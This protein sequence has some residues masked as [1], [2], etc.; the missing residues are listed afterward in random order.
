MKKHVIFVVSYFLILALV[1]GMTFFLPAR[2]FS[3][4]ENRVL[5]QAPELNVD[6]LL[7]GDFQEDLSLFLSDQIPG[8][9]FWIKTNTQIKKLLG[10]QEINGV[11]LGKDGYYFQQFTEDSYS[12]N[13][14]KT[15]FLLIESFASKQSVPV[16][17]MPVPTPAVALSDKLPANAPMYNA[18]KVWQTMQAITGSCNFID[19][20]Q[21]FKNAD[22]QAYY[23]TDHHWTT[24]GAYLA[25][26]AYCE[27]MDITPKALEDFDLTCVSEEF[28]GTIYSKTLDSAAGPDSVYAIGTLPQIT[29]TFDETTVSNTLYDDEKL[30]EKDKYAYFFGG[31]YGKVD[32][33]TEAN[34]GKR[35]LVIKD[36]FANSMVPY[37]LEQYEHITML[38]LRY[39]NGSVSQVMA[40]EEITEVLFL[41][42]MTNLL[43]DSGIAKLG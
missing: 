15:L 1:A 7:S 24:E 25:Y 20:R 23:R 19:L 22:F 14:M 16:T 38:D 43:T 13:K 2:N 8:R 31:N 28:Y 26:S 17:V 40:Q 34:N 4:N 35:L 5:N 32:I 29:V 30:E 11:Y 41:Y 27:E 21:D 6:R 18:D 12:S 36:S 9:E 33:E 3:E 37:L 39:F 10:K 42:E